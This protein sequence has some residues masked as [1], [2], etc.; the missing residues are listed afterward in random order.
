LN[1]HF[2]FS[3]GQTSTLI[4]K[5]ITKGDESQQQQ[6][7]QQQQQSKPSFL[8]RVLFIWFDKFVLLGQN[9]GINSQNLWD[10]DPDFR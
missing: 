1:L 4:E 10:L 3:E 6:Q 7:Q 8:S 9:R 2:C 5:T